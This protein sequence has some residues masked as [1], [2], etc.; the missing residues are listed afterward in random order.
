MY[1]IT[2]IYN[3]GKG[4]CIRE[5]KE[6]KKISTNKSKAKGLRSPLKGE[7]PWR[8]CHS[9]KLRLPAKSVC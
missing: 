2:K 7:P 9:G 3:C 4:D 8:P 5:K 1:K 6:Y